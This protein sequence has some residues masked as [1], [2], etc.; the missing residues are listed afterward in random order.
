MHHHNRFRFVPILRVPSR[1]CLLQYSLKI[2]PAEKEQ[3]QEQEQ[4]TVKQRAKRKQTS[5]FKKHII[6]IQHR[7]TYPER[8]T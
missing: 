6:N 5:G 7:P 3:E 1:H 8:L 4:G 2:Y